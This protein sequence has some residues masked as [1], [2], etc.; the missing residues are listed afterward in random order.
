MQKEALGSQRLGYVLQRSG[1]E[2][3]EFLI[4]QD[5]RKT[6]KLVHQTKKLDEERNKAGKDKNEMD[7]KRKLK[8]DE[9]KR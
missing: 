6:C 4:S 9:F 2:V 3:W 1:K 7:M 8:M 5:L